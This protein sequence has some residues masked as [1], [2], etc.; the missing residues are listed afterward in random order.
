MDLPPLRRRQ[1]PV[2]QHRRH[3]LPL[4]SLTQALDAE[5]R[6]AARADQEG[7]RGGQPERAGP[8]PG[9]QTS[10]RL[11]SLNQP[12]PIARSIHPPALDP[13]ADID[14]ES[15]DASRDQGG[16]PALSATELGLGPVVRSSAGFAS[17]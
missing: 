8:D 6:G 14:P 16:Y 3:H 11:P 5:L 7:G 2:D 1:L 9:L 13:D 17:W 15:S 10:P 4:R 12:A